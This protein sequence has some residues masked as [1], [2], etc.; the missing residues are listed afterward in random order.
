MTMY[1]G[2]AKGSKI[3]KASV[4]ES[5]PLATDPRFSSSRPGT[6]KEK[7]RRGDTQELKEAAERALRA[8]EGGTEERLRRQGVITSDGRIITEA[9]SKELGRAIKEGRATLGPSEDWRVAFAKA[10]ADPRLA[11]AAGY[12]G[13]PRAAPRGFSRADPRAASI[14]VRQRLTEAFATSSTREDNS[15]TYGDGKPALVGDII[16]NRKTQM[17][18]EVEGATSVGVKVDMG[19][20]GKLVVPFESLVEFVLMGR[21]K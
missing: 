21:A 20:L 6:V 2:G 9:E 18:G 4:E 14:N 12:R 3:Y 7:Y 13:D 11:R 1:S 5:L 15:A 17:L 16:Q 8:L 19:D 10:A